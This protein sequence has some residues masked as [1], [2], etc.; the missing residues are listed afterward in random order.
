MPQNAQYF[1]YIKGELAGGV[2]SALMGLPAT[3]VYGMMVF[4]PLGT[5]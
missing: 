2:A 1:S 3:L 5:A 4:A